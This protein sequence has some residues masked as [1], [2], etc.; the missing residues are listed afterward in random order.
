MSSVYLLS[1]F[2][3][4]AKLIACLLF[5]SFLNNIRQMHLSACIFTLKK[6][7]AKIISLYICC[8]PITKG[9]EI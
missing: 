7:S 9:G 5:W 3:V 6:P 4:L 8:I 2:I 1:L